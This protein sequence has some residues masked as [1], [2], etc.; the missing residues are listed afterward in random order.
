MVTEIIK[1]N[2]TKVSCLYALKLSIL[3]GNP[4]IMAGDLA[5][6]AGVNRDSLYIL[7]KRWQKWEYIR[8][9]RNVNP[10]TYCLAK[11]GLRYLDKLSAWY[12]YQK[13]VFEEVNAIVIPSFYWNMVNSANGNINRS[14]F[15]HWPFQNSSD[16]MAV[17][18]DINGRL[19]YSGYSQVR[20]KKTN[21][22]TALYAI[23][24]ILGLKW[25][26]SL[27]NRLIEEKFISRNE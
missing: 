27:V 8:T 5:A 23:R 9:N 12:P 15:I 20:I 17:Y 22:L 3:G 25:G 1:K 13:E 11:T 21:C 24:D 26:E 7:L 4:W 6:M 14:C 18:P 19:T 10:R 2:K 16:F